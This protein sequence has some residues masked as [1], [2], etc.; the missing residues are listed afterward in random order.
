MKRQYVAASLAA[1]SALGVLFVAAPAHGIQEREQNGTRNPQNIGRVSSVPIRVSGQITGNRD[2]DV[3]RFELSPGQNV[4]AT[5]TVNGDIDLEVLED[6]NLD[7]KLAGGDTKKIS[8]NEGKQTEEVIYRNMRS[9]YGFVRIMDS[10]G[11][12]LS[13]IVAYNLTI[14]AVSAN[15]RPVIQNR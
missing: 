6:S 7:G 2:E 5:L 10:G 9:R 11:A 15:G 8:I 4:K 13:G 12:G 1:I 3:F 14:T